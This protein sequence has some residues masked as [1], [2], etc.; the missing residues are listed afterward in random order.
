MS[1]PSFAASGFLARMQPN[2]E[3]TRYQVLGERSSGTNFA[4]RMLGRNTSLTPTEALGW[5]H[6]FPHAAAIPPDLLVIGLVRRADDWARSMHAKPWHASV[7]LQSLAFSDFIRAEWDTYIDRPRYFEGATKAGII[8]QPLMHDRHPL[9]GKRFANIFALRHAK[10]A[11]LL[12]YLERDCNF[13]LLRMED[14]IAAPEATLDTV[15]SAVGLAARNAK[16]KPV[17]KRLG[18]KFKAAIEARPE[19]PKTLQPDDL[20][21]M[22]KHVNGGQEQALGYEY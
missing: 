10:I 12:S 13:I 20:A 17:F 22:Q 8:G 11:G 14:M 4:K 2:A 15:R 1:Q 6:G 3:I 9:T 7:A 5:K 19:T 18:S 21:F 16:F